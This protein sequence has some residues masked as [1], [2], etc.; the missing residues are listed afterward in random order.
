MSPIINL[1]ANPAASYGE[2]ARL[3]RFRSLIVKKLGFITVVETEKR[4]MERFDLELTAYL[5][6]T[7]KSKQQKSVKLR[8]SNICAGGT[9]F[10][11]NKPLTVGTDVKLDIILPLNKFKN[12]TRKISHIY[13]TGSVIRTS[14]QGMAICFDKNHKIL[15]LKN[16]KN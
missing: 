15:P 14:Q 2:C 7:D 6:V 4:K 11:T 1:L 12:M 5:S 10:K 9:F 8:T 16:G 13:F 3:C